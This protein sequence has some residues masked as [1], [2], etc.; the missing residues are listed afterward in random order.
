MIYSASSLLLATL[1]FNAASVWGAPV[2]VSSD[3]S[4]VVRSTGDDILPRKMAI[5]DVVPHQRSV[6]SEQVDARDTASSSSESIEARDPLPEVERIVRRFPRQIY[7]DYYTKRSPSPDDEPVARS[8]EVVERRFP[9]R[10]LYERHEARS[11]P[12]PPEARS[13]QPEPADIQRRYPRKVYADLYQ[14][15]E[16][17]PPINVEARDPAPELTDSGRRFPR[18]VLAERYVK[19]QDDAAAP[20]PAADPA[21][22]TTEAAGAPT[23]AA[24]TASTSA[25]V[26]ASAS[27]STA[28]SPVVPPLDLNRIV[29]DITSGDLN[30]FQPGTTIK[31]TTLLI[32]KITHISDKGN[33]AQNAP[34][35]PPVSGGTPASPATPSS[36]TS[37]AASP[38]STATTGGEAAPAPESTVTPPAAPAQGEADPSTPPAEGTTPPAEGAASRRSLGSVIRRQLG[39]SGPAWAS[40]L[41]RNVN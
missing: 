7:H 29:K 24:P 26:T 5:I 23:P 17:S 36:S 27:T 28:T 20:N 25:S 3:G 39:Y 21:A 37:A 32:N 34:V 2:P 22:A 6:D 12:T 35:V 10:A 19:R 16:S 9:R 1:V 14:K 30:S 33:A 31:E 13:E 11:N 4:P 41:K 18:Q 40:H 38:S 15:R 8:P